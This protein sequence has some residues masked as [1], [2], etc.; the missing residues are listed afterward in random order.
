MKLPNIERAT[1]PAE[2][3]TDYLLSPIHPE[4]K[5]KATFFTGYG[6][7]KERWLEIADVL[8]SH[9]YGHKVTKTT[10][11]PFGMKYVIEGDM[12]MPNG[13]VVFIRVVWFIDNDSEIPRF[14]TAYPIE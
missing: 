14:I 3:I 8:L 13:V 4:G 1:V 6:F 11:T 2:K 9:A 12:M 5:H 7:S 10:K